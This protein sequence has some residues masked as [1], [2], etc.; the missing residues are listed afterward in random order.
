MRQLTA[1][2]SPPHKPTAAVA[3]QMQWVVDT[4]TPSFEKVSTCTTMIVVKKSVD[5][6]EEILRIK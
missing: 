2:T 5:A 4:G 1:D 6:A 3:P